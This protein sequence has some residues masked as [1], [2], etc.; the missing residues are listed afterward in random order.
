[1]AE[2]NQSNDRPWLPGSQIVMRETWHAQVWTARPVT[3][4]EDN[5]ELLALYMAP[6][7]I[8]K[9]PRVFGADRIPEVMPDAPW[10][11]VDLT[12]YGGGAL[13]LSRPGEP[14]MII[15]FRSD[16]NTQLTTWYVNLQDPL[17]RTSLG[18]DYLDQELDILISPDLKTYRW[19]DEE[20][21]AELQRRGRIASEK[22]ARLR[23]V[24]EE[25][26]AQRHTP[27]SLFRQGWEDWSPSPHWTRPTLPPKWDTV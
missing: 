3:V 25:V 9:H 6:G 12:W 8:Y 10:R 1:M 17:R 22:A 23:A 2:M 7:T 5:A 27:N 18:F 15:G 11:L 24:G 14:Y 26:L 13:Y 4:V 21:F 19:K 20:N 16:D